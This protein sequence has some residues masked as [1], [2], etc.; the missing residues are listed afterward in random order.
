MLCLKVSQL[1]VII[2]KMSIDDDYVF[3]GDD[4]KEAD[5]NH[6]HDDQYIREV[7]TNSKGIKVRGKDL[8]WIPA[9]SFGSDTLYKE[10]QIYKESRKHNLG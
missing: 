8:E 4:G 6:V 7:K 9:S 3:F 5:V 10:S 2:I 1:K